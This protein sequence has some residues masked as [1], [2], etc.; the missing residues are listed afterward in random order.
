[1]T[2]YQ[3][4]NITNVTPSTDSMRSAV[5]AQVRTYYRSRNEEGVDDNRSNLIAFIGQTY[6]SERNES[7]ISFDLNQPLIENTTCNTGELVV[8][9][10]LSVS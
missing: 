6:D 5:E 10:S 3:T 4:V 9:N 1:M 2:N 7:L 8:L